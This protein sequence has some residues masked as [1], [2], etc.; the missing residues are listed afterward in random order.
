MAAKPKGS[1]E[2]P[3]KIRPQIFEMVRKK[4]EIGRKVSGISGTGVVVEGVVFS[5]GKCVTRWISAV[6]CVQVWD[7]FEAFKAVHIDP[8]PDNGTVIV[9][10]EEDKK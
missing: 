5:N 8:H 10:Q 3:K 4:D 2:G 9:W 6:S 7:S 1:V